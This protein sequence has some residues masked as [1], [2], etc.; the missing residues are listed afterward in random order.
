MKKV[1][2][3]NSPIIEAEC[4]TG[5]VKMITQSSS[6]EGS[7]L[8]ICKEGYIGG[9]VS[10]ISFWHYPF[11]FIG[12]CTVYKWNINIIYENEQWTLQKLLIANEWKH[13]TACTVSNNFQWT[14]VINKYKIYEVFL[15]SHFN[16]VHCK[17]PNTSFFYP[18]CEYAHFYHLIQ[19]YLLAQTLFLFNRRS[20][21]RQGRESRI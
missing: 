10:P 11:Q 20:V 5:R 4:N 12:K 3:T 8:W 2:F 19:Q 14:W 18:S 21:M 13:E 1:C 9:V 6:D 17:N 15:F 16:T 7:G